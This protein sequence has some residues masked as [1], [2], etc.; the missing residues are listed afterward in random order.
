MTARFAGP[1]SFWTLP[2][3]FRKPT[4][5]DLDCAPVAVYGPMGLNI[6]MVLL[7]ESQFYILVEGSPVALERQHEVRA[8]LADPE[9]DLVPAPRRV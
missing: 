6:F 2:S 7:L 8:P 3:S 1:L 4:S 9:G 5:P